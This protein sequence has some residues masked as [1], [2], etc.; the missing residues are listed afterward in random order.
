MGKTA[1]FATSYAVIIASAWAFRD[2]FTYAALPL[3]SLG[4]LIFSDAAAQ[5]EEPGD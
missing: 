4:L 3:F 1:T 5:R 2:G